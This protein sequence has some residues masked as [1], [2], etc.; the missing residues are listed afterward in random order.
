M[1]IVWI[2]KNGDAF[3]ATKFCL[4]NYFNCNLHLNCA[5]AIA[6]LIPSNIKKLIKR[7]QAMV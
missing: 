7:T 1:Q 5:M 4:L 6:Y 3:L 2:G